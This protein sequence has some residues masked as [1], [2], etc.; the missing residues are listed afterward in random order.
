MGDEQLVTTVEEAAANIERFA[1]ELERSDAL[2]SVMSYVRAWHAESQEDGT[3]LVAPSKYAGYRNN[4]ARTYAKQHNL[5]DGR[6]TER[7]LS[8]WFDE[9]VPGDR[10]Y[11][12]IKAATLHLF[13]KYGR[14]PNK[15]FRVHALRSQLS[16]GSGLTQLASRPAFRSRITIDPGVVGGR[17]AIRHMRVRVSDI[18]DLL[19]AGATRKDILKDF[20]YLE[21]DDISAALAYAA[22]SVSAAVIAT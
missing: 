9:V 6:R 16:V 18:L 7:V 8:A 12:E 21:D 13:A 2:Q 17:A 19:A 11:D 15:L 14:T 5:R 22:E 10:A 3:W 1:K 20:P 4:D